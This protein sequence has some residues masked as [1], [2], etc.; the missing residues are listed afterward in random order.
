MTR[1]AI[2][3]LLLV[4]SPLSLLAITGSRLYPSSL[5]L[6]AS[7]SF[8]IYC[9]YVNL[10]SPSSAICTLSRRPSG[11]DYALGP[12]SYRVLFRVISDFIPTRLD[13]QQSATPVSS[14]LLLHC[15]REY[16]GSPFLGR[17]QYPPHADFMILILFVSSISILKIRFHTDGLSDYRKIPRGPAT[18]GFGGG[19]GFWG[20]VPQ[21]R[22][23]FTKKAG[24]HS[25][26]I[27]TDGGRC[28]TS[29][30][31]FARA[32]SSM[33][34]VP[35]P[36]SA[37]SPNGSGWNEG[38]TEKEASRPHVSLAQSTQIKGGFIST[39]PDLRRY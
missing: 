22:A 31:N 5:S 15:A 4:V 3:S 6:L 24:H 37:G 10:I 25:Q 16:F 36:T 26:N 20:L 38:S 19:R 28:A 1:C 33:P 17:R 32:R 2:L 23:P 18:D 11:E 12:D 21:Y 7:R 13:S 8:L 9:P 14:P 27:Y 29:A 39:E 30:T 35:A 34:S